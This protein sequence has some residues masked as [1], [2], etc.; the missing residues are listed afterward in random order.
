MNRAC[1]YADKGVSG[2]RA[3][4]QHVGEYAGRA[5]RPTQGTQHVVYELQHAEST[6]PAFTRWCQ[7]S[8]CQR[9]NR[10]IASAVQNW[11]AASKE[12]T[13]SGRARACSRH[14]WR[15][16]SRTPPTRFM[17]SL[18]VISLTRFPD[19]HRWIDRRQVGAVLPQSFMIFWPGNHSTPLSEC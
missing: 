7:S 3:R 13:P 17:P 1:T 18:W 9:G 19:V 6:M 15:H 14:T 5:E 8:P 10:L 4:S 12:H 16:T 11:P 2:F